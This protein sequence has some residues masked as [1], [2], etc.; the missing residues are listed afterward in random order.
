MKKRHRKELQFAL[1]DY[2]TLLSAFS[3]GQDS[4]SV[5]ELAKI[6]I[7]DILLRSRRLPTS[8][9]AQHTIQP[10]ESS[11]RK[12]RYARYLESAHWKALRKVALIRDQY[13]CQHCGTPEALRVHHKLYRKNYTDSLPEDLLTL[14]ENCHVKEHARLKELKRISKSNQ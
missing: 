11:A 9:E 8:F 6:R 2:S 7:A 3:P 5:V 14:C 10:A 4:Y 1:D 13:L 12:T